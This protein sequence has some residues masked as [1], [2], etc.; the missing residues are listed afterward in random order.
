VSLQIVGDIRPIEDSNVP[1]EPSMGLSGYNRYLHLTV[2]P[3]YFNEWD[4]KRKQYF[5]PDIKTQYIK[6]VEY[7]TSVECGICLEDHSKKEMIACNCSHE[8]GQVCFK[9]WMDTC[10]NS[11][12]TI[13]CPN[14][15]EEVTETKLFKQKGRP[16]KV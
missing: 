14:C 16:P 9:S 6:I 8:F 1:F 2:S 13:S 4:Q 12:R 7:N 3:F 11:K 15:R 10:K 5:I